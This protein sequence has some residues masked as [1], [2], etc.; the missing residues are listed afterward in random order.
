M[1]LEKGPQFCV[2]GCSRSLRGEQSE[3]KGQDHS[4]LNHAK[5]YAIGSGGQETHLIMEEE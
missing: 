5:E 1:G 3:I 4:A 2:A